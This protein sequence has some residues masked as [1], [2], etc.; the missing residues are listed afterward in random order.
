VIMMSF[1][2]LF[3]IEIAPRFLLTVF[4]I[5]R[6]FREYMHIFL[7]TQSLKLHWPKSFGDVSNFVSTSRS[8]RISSAHGEMSHGTVRTYRIIQCVPLEVQS[9]RSNTKSSVVGYAPVIL[10]I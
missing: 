7:R 4:C 2:W 6:A 9:L 1:M 8:P 5:L 10:S 3:I